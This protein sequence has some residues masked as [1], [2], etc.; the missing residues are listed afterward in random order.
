MQRPCRIIR[1]DE[2]GS[3][4]RI[5]HHF[6]QEKPF[7]KAKLKAI[8][9][10][11]GKAEAEKFIHRILHGSWSCGNISTKGHLIDYDS[12][13]VV[14]GR[15]PQFS[16]TKRYCAN[17]FGLES[18]GQAKI[19]QALAEHPKI[20][21]S[22]SSFSEL[23]SEMKQGLS[24]QIAKRL[25]Y[26]LGF[27]DYKNIFKRE[28]AAFERLALSFQELSRWFYLEDAKRFASSKNYQ[29][30]SPHTL[31]T[32]LFDFSALFRVY[33]LLI[34]SQRYS[35][36]KA[37]EILLGE[38]LRFDELSLSR[39]TKRLPDEVIEGK[40]SEELERVHA[41]SEQ[42]DSLKAQARVFLEELKNLYT[43]L[44]CNPFKNE[45]NAYLIN[46]DR[47]YLFPV[48]NLIP[49]ILDPEI[50]A[51]AQEV[52]SYLDLLIKASQRQPS[53]GA[54]QADYRIYQEGYSYLGLDQKG[55]FQVV[56]CLLK[57]PLS[58][59]K[60]SGDYQLF[61]NQKECKVKVEEEQLTWKISTEKLPLE[62]L[63]ENYNRYASFQREKGRLYFQGSPLELND[64]FTIDPSWAYYFKLKSEA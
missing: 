8:A 40:V 55:Q 50:A 60:I 17:F 34:R 19:L 3:L 59:S 63:L 43:S 38:Q 9:K 26:L 6:Y 28:Q 42:L 46:E 51:E 31:H 54:K 14:K 18:Q 29:S 39:L 7:S 27:P 30:H 23:N 1:I 4:D 48:F 41:K 57:E 15:Q 53:G 47:L 10:A 37:L 5:T 45:A 62:L 24:L 58:L 61:F 35:H 21:R 64:F 11:F 49:S 52:N 36:E 32:L 33:P 22:R 12:I 2:N 13:A 44:D 16:V 25:A 20:N 56:Y